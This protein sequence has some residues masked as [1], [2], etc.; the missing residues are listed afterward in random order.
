[1]R[2]RYSPKDITA[3]FTELE[4]DNDRAAISVGGSML[5]YA[6]EQ[7]LQSRFREAPDKGVESGILFVETGIL[8][9]FWQKIWAAY[10]LQLI[11]PDT[12]RNFDLIRLIRNAVS[13]DMNPVSFDGTPEIG[14]RCRELA[15][16][17]EMG[18]MPSG[19]R[20]RFVLAVEFYSANLLLRTSDSDPVV[21]EA[22]KSLV[23][24]I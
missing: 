20:G 9:T 10:F 21:S 1:M 23:D 7:C 15:V 13:H 19:L 8:G 14:N 12:R 6:L 16:T 11:G 18:V 2:K 4:G 17:D 3:I 22:M 24:R 5:E